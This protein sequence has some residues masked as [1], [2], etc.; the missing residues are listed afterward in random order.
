MKWL[1][2]IIVIYIGQLG[3]GVAVQMS[4]QVGWQMCGQVGERM[5][6]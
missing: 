6:D 3:R 4:Y 1:Y 5:S 2:N